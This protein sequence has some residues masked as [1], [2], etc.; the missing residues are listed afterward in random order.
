M[1]YAEVDGPPGF[2]NLVRGAVG[3]LAQH[4]LD[5]LDFALNKLHNG[6]P[7]NG[8]A[9]F[10]KLRPVLVI[11]LVWTELHNRGPLCG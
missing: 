2:E 9:A 5:C 4:M 1:R 11:G 8:F 10:F 6:T 7:F 3:T